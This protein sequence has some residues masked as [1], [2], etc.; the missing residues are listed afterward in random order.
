MTS[1]LET[2][3]ALAREIQE[4]Q[5]LEALLGR[6]ASC[7]AK[8]VD[9][10]RASIRLLDAR[11]ERLV[12]VCRA[13]EP[14]HENPE[15]T[16]RVGE[17]LMGWIV[18]KA[19]PIRLADAENDPRFAPRPGMRDRM[20]SFLGV[21]I[22][23]GS[24]CVGVVSAVSSEADAFSREH[25]ELVTLLA[26][27]CAPYLEIQRLSRLAT[28]DPLTGALNRRGGREALPSEAPPPRETDPPVSVVLLDL[29]H[30]KSVN[31][32]Y[33]HVAGD[34]VLRQVAGVL[35]G[36]VRSGDAVIRYGGEEFLLVLQGVEQ[37]TAV[38]VAERTREAIAST[39]FRVGDETLQVTASFGVA[40]RRAGEGR[41]DLYRRADAAMYEAKHKGRNR[42]EV[43]L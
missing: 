37:T 10:P 29:D 20:G 36:I 25:E 17:G 34:Q 6:I 32:T 19:R 38:R 22:L 7:T 39:A 24:M 27:I 21:P 5:S 12:A 40:Q 30:F 15:Q 1:P 31:D 4:P 42:V 11:G 28:V 35:A 18:Q 14:L 26:A 9:C 41:E 16:F 43:A 3:A 2:L 13:G 8:L 23:S 33:G